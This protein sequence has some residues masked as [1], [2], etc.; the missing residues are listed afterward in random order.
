MS[1]KNTFIKAQLF[2][3]CF[4]LLFS[5]SKEE[6][7]NDVSESR[8]N[9]AT[10]AEY[11]YTGDSASFADYIHALILDGEHILYWEE[12]GSPIYVYDYDEGGDAQYGIGD[13]DT[14]T[15]GYIVNGSYE[16]VKKWA[17]ERMEEGFV[18]EIWYQ[19]T[20]GKY[21]AVVRRREA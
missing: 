15:D 10:P 21:V 16:V 7:K 5:C 13:K 4:A 8:S 18:V 19:R 12:E 11:Y 9:F 1:K 6:L 20:H 3:G 2:L 14:V 17:D